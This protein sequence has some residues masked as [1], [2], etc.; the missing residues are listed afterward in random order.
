M[1]TGPVAR[2]WL[3]PTAHSD[4]QVTWHDDEDG[5]AVIS[6]WRDDRCVASAPLTISEAASLTSFLVAHL[7]ERAAEAT[8]ADPS[9]RVV[10]DA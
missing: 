5:H 4:L 8:Q 9:L 10:P 2:R 6:L 1:A 7:G 3:Q